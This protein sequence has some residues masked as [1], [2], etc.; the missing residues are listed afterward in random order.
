M[1]VCMPVR[2]PVANVYRG[3]FWVDSLVHDGNVLRELVNLMG[4][5]RHAGH[6]YAGHSYVGHSYVGHDY[7]GHNYTSS[8]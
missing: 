3:S 4:A 5:D 1:S 2:M 6:N 7:I 8:I